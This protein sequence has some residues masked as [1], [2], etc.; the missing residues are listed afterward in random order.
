VRTG[1]EGWLWFAAAVVLA[2]AAL[3]WELVRLRATERAWILDRRVPG[4][5]KWR[6][7]VM[8]VVLWFLA[9]PHLLDRLLGTHRVPATASVGVDV[10]AW[11]GARLQR[12][13]ADSPAG[14]PVLIV[15]SLVTRPW[16]LDLAPGCSL[17][18]ALNDAGHDVYLLDWDDPTRAVAAQ[19]LGEKAEALRRA[20]GAIGGE[21]GVHVLCYCSGATIA[22]IAAAV[23]PRM[24]RSLALIAPMVD[25]AVPGGMRPLMAS[26]WLVPPLLLDGNGCV[27]AAAIREAFHLLRPMALRAARQRW[28]LRH[29]PASMRIAGALTRWTWEQRSLP[30]GAFFD[31]VDLFRTNALMNDGWPLD[32]RAADLR[33]IT[34]PTL[35]AVTDRDHIVPIASSLALTHLLAGQVDVVRCRGGHVSMVAGLDAQTT[36][37]PSLSRWFAAIEETPATT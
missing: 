13:A 8:R 7:T 2:L 6:A 31:L 4:W 35:V 27:P 26:R 25:T 5:R 18:E 12:F 16:I 21:S 30:G 10:A 15:H 20:I 32:G 28:R 14:E 11:P 9:W 34:L 17:V 1:D 33:T 36:L 3:A 37:Y 22:L 19:G 29:D 24:M 23:D